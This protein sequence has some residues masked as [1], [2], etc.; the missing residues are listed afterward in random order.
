M[1]KANSTIFEKTV[2]K[3]SLHMKRKIPISK[4]EKYFNFLKM[5]KKN[6]QFLKAKIFY[7]KL[8]SCEHNLKLA[9]EHRKNN[10]HFVSLK[11]LYIFL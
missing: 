2:Q 10:F 9:C 4:N 11:F 8:V 7:E 1:M 6:V 3:T 5:D